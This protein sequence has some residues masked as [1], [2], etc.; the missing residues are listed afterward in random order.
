MSALDCIERECF[1]N[2]MKNVVVIKLYDF[3]SMNLFSL[4]L[5]I[6]FMKINFKNLF[7]MFMHQSS[8]SE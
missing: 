5:I 4:K 2:E 6:L 3:N 8:V 7:Y 1:N